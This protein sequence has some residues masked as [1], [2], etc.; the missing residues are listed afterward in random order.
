[1]EAA[2][3]VPNLQF[4]ANATKA[5]FTLLEIKGWDPVLAK[6]GLRYL[7]MAQAKDMRNPRVVSARALYQRVAEKYG[8][9][10]AP[11]AGTRVVGDQTT[12]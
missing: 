5:I 8:V 6:R 10:T 3:R 4:L 2:E 1:M 12:L 9:A 11:L 7:Q